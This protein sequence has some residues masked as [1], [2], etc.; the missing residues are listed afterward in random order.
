MFET[1]QPGQSLEAGRCIELQGAER[2]SGHGG[3][4]PD[5]SACADGEFGESVLPAQE[6]E[7]RQCVVVLHLDFGECPCCVRGQPAWG[8]GA[9]RVE[10]GPGAQSAQTVELFVGPDGETEVPR[11]EAGDD[12]VRVRGGVEPRPAPD[13]LGPDGERVCSAVESTAESDRAVEQ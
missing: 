13:E 8:D 11:I 2:Q 9:S 10:H 5:L 6:R 1:G 4:V 12:L 7:V 3:Q